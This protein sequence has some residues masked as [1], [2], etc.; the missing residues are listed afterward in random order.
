MN[1]I[2]LG[3]SSFAVVAVLSLAALGSSAATDSYKFTARGV[4]T[5]VDA[6]TKIVT[7]SITH[8]SEKAKNDLIGET[9]DFR[10]STAKVYKSAGSKKVRVKVSSINDGDEIVM[11]GAAK[12]DGS[13]AVSWAEINDRSFTL[14]GTLK[15][16]DSTHKTLKIA[17]TSSTYKSS[18]YNGKDVVVKYTG[19][20]VFKSG[21]EVREPDDI[22]ADN[23]T[24]KVTGK[25]V[26]SNWDLDTYAENL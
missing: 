1:K 4:V 10:S 26:G 2:L 12:S 25:I 3:G 24:V 23:Q 20:T 7:V 21:G 5:A 9:K 18:T 19:N 14:N 13:F 16:H 11:K 17:V 8:A 6:D 22:V 15:E